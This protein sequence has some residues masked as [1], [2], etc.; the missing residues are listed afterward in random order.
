ML[1]MVHLS[2]LAK[3]M[4]AHPIRLAVLV[5]FLFPNGGAN[6]DFLNNVSRYSIGLVAVTRCGDNNDT[7]VTHIQFAVPV[8][9][10]NVRV[11]APFSLGFASYIH[12]NLFTKRNETVIL[13]LRDVP[14]QI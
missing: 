4:T 3:R 1:M 10:Q 2:V 9:N 6:L 8:E 11:G 14:T 7:C 13:H 5:V 12:E